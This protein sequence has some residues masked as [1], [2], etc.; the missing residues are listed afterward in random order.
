MKRKVFRTSWLALV[1]FP[2]AAVALTSQLSVNPPAASPGA[3]VQLRG[4][5]PAGQTDLCFYWEQAGELRPVARAAADPAGGFSLNAAVPADAPRGF[6]RWAVLPAG[7]PVGELTYADFE[8]L[9]PAPGQVSGTVKNA[10]GGTAGAGVPVRLLDI[11]GL[12]VGEVLTDRDGRFVFPDLPAGRYVVQATRDGYA[13][14]EATVPA[15][16]LA[17]VVVG[18]VAADQT[19]PL[20]P[21][22]LVGAGG[23]AVPGGVF[24]GTQP[25]KLGDWTDVPMARLVSLKGKGLAPLK[26]RFWVELQRMLLPAEAPLVLV[27]QLKKAGQVVA[28]AETDATSLLFDQSPFNFPAHVAEFNSLELPPGKL[29]LE[30]VAVTTLFQKVGQWQ[31]PVEVV[32]L[33]QR[34]Y[35]GHVKNPSLTVTKQDLSRLRYEFK[36]ALPKVPGVGTPLFEEDL[37][38]EFK[39]LHNRLDLGI[40]LTERFYSDGN[41]SG[42]GKAVAQLTLLDTPLINQSLNLQVQGASLPGATYSLSLWSVPLGEMPPIPIWGAAL[43]SPIDLCGL[44]FNGEVGIVLRLGGSV[45]LGAQVKTDLRTTATVSPSLAVSLPIGANVEAAI[46]KATAQIKPQATLSAPL[47]LDPFHQPPIYWDGLC[48]V[49]SGNANLALNCCGLGFDKSVDLFPPI[50]VGNCPAG[51]HGPAP[52]G[53]DSLAFAPPRHASIAFSPAGFALAVWEGYVTVDGEI[54]RTAPVHSVFDGAA[55]SPP[56]PIAGPEFA[57]WEPQ[58]TFLN[59]RRAIV[60]WVRPGPAGA[61]LAGPEPQGVCDKI[62]SLLNWGCSMVG[63]AVDLAES[64]WDAI[65]L[66]RATAAPGQPRL[67]ISGTWNPPTM[68]SHD[69]PLDV[70]PV[71]ASDPATGDAVLVWLREQEPIA[72]RQPALALYYARRG[73]SGWGAAERVD[74][75]SNAFDLQPSF[76]FDRRGRPSAV[77][78]RD[79][80]GDLGTPHD[81]GLVFSVLGTTGWSVP[82]ALA[83]LPAAPWTPSLDFDDANAPVVAFVVPAVNPQT[84]ELLGGDGLLSTL[85]VAR[86]TGL[87]WVSAPVGRDTR[88]ERPLLRVTPDNRALVLFRGFGDALRVRP[89]GEVTVAEADLATPELNWG[90]ARLTKNDRLN[91]QVTAELNPQTGD[92]LVLWESRD[93][94]NLLAE[95]E[96]LTLPARRLPD[97]TFAEPAIEFSDPFPTP[98][99]PVRITVRVTNGGLAPLGVVSYQ[100]HFFDREPLRGVT[101]F[102]TRFLRGPLAPGAEEA[103]TA[104]YTPTDRA[105]RTFYVVVDAADA[106]PEADEANNRAEA[107]WGGLPAPDA[108]AATPDARGG[109][110]RLA[111][112]NP[113]ADASVRTWIWRARAG[114]RESE[115]VGISTGE[116]FV[117]PLAEPGV[118]YTYLLAAFDP[119]N[120]RSAATETGP[121]NVPNPGPPDA[122]ALR[123]SAVHYRGTITLTWNVLPAGQLEAANA[124]TGAATRWQPLTDGVKRL[125]GIPQLTLPAA[126]GQRFFR[127]TV[128]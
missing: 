96:L 128:P 101:P 48:L 51:L 117:D 121:V 94:A 122:L 23:L 66:S 31:F 16:G 8:V 41:W 102:A 20:P 99:Q 46:C 84:G 3:V 62:S 49:F 113:V 28:H 37:D 33:G 43:P 80:D 104:D 85:H 67:A 127:L 47:V 87:G 71:L 100:V 81:R 15:G 9:A 124:L 125:G 39:K 11:S 55:W 73:R 22:M 65:F 97:L 63:G 64:V 32:D 59:P 53:A 24:V 13:P 5:V 26:V 21:V 95:P 91:W 76:R 93:P 106:V 111:W 72:G 7:R 14:A 2:F 17:D 108:V 112:T 86:R 40:A 29:A 114:S 57:G 88:A 19:L 44:K 30:V 90:L 119:Q 120:V 89:Q 1:S 4:E 77:W 56:Q 6:G 36:G 83:P 126:Q 54:Q 105:W 78:V 110:A 68:L 27:F 103:V 115:L 35:A 107:A 75:R 12:P 42:S 52:A 38:F 34:W 58:V 109:A 69:L 10:A 50:K 98:T 82:E 61:A 60:V 92:P 74:P 116:S 118:E 18:Q 70:R 123:L 25:V 79:A 45:A